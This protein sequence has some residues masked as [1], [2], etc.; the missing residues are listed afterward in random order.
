MHHSH[1]NHKLM[2][3]ALLFFCLQQKTENLWKNFKLMNMIF[4]IMCHVYFYVHVTQIWKMM[5]HQCTSVHHLFG[6]R[7]CGIF[8]SCLSDIWT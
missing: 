4:I 7:V 3:I 8:G 6:E 2:E 5:C 1:T